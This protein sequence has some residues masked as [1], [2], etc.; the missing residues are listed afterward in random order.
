MP[1]ERH[2][3]MIDGETLA[4]LIAV[5]R[6]R[7]PA[8]LC[9]KN[10]RLINVWTGDVLCRDLAVH[11]GRFAGWG[12][13]QGL[14]EMALNGAYV[15]P[16][17]IDA[18]LHLE[19]TLLCAEEFAA[20]VVPHGTTAVVLDPHEIANVLG[21]RGVRALMQSCEGL[22]VDFFFTLPSCV[23][24]ASLDPS[25]AVLRG[26]DLQTLRGH[27]RVLGLAEMMNFPGVLAMDAE[28]LDKIVLFQDTS[29]DG[30]CPGLQGLDLNAY[31]ACGLHSDHETTALEEAREKLAKGLAL[32]I[33]E[34]SQSKDLAALLDA[35]TD[36]TWPRCLFV[37]DDR[38]PTDLLREGHMDAIVNRAMALGMDPVRALTLAS[39]NPAQLFGLRRRGALAPGYMADF[40]VSPTLR[41]WNPVMVFKDGRLVARDG[42]LCTPIA[43]RKDQLMKTL[44]SPMAV[45]HVDPH[46]FR[47]P[48]A[49]RELRVI[50]LREGSLITDHLILPATVQDGWAVCDP[51][52]DLLKMVVF[53]R[54]ADPDAFNQP[55][56][57]FVQ[58]FGL[59]EGALASTVAHDA[60][61]LVAVGASDDA[62]GYA[63]RA[64]VES[65]G[66]LSVSDSKG[67]IAHMPLPLA[68]LMSVEPLDRVCGALEEVTRAAH[69]LGSTLQHPF[70]ALSFLALPVIPALKM[71]SRGLVDV[72]RFEIVP[73]FV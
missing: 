48:A 4:D 7:K 59:K 10:A 15:A 53:N 22:P 20:A 46:R 62:I 8:E 47:V 43:T 40:S 58:G 12:T 38:H 33:R 35:V 67:I 49:G 66:G 17:F 30:H 9:L 72:E 31:I 64:V 65:R 27:A 23:P 60:H 44:E 70:M 21:L 34:G 42:R 68:G 6:G 1:A 18:H 29:M 63:V 51:S 52:R 54:Y 25:G 36:T 19:S 24:A 3:T 55:A 14:Q 50:G 37:S 45:Q 69:A 71:S 11:R 56:V 39:W 26:S 13:Y 28:V 41:P 2:A 57:G 73:L 5:A 16:G 32:M 61:H